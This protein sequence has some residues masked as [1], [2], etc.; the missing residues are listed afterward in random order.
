MTI[1]LTIGWLL[2]HAVGIAAAVDS[3]F[4][5]RSSQATIAWGLCLLLFPFVTVPLYLIFG[6]RR[7]RAYRRLCKRFSNYAALRESSRQKSDAATT[8]LT[9][10]DLKS[11]VERV[12][13]SIAGRQFTTGNKVKFLTSG[14]SFYEALLKDINA[15]QHHVFLCFYVVNSDNIGERLAAAL[16]GAK[17]RGVE[18]KFLYDRIGSFSLTRRY[19]EE[20]ALSGVEFT[21]FNTERSWRSC[22]HANFRNH[23]KIAVIDNRVAYVGGFNVGD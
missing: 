11:E 23:R 16:A 8:E 19:C 12:L 18:V 2:V 5:T 15:A 10:I 20:F 22:F 13:E 1:F 9:P 14:K 21:G 3:L 7:Q 17:S 6:R 4:S